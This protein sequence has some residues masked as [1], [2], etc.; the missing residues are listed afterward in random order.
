MKVGNTQLLM[1]LGAAVVAAGSAMAQS[2][3]F[4][5]PL[6][7]GSA[8]AGPSSSTTMSS[9]TMMMRQDDGDD[10]YEIRIEGDKVK[11]KV[12]GKEVPEDRVVREKDQIKILDENGK[13]LSTF[14]VSQ[15]GAVSAGK[16]SATT[17]A[18]RAQNRGRSGGGTRVA[19]AA[20][21]PPEPPAAAM[22]GWEP[23]K[24]MLGINM[25]EP[26]DGLLKAYGLEKGQSILIDRVIEGLPAEKAGIR[27]NDVITEIDGKK[28]ATPEALRD[29][30][31]DKEPGDTVTFTVMRKGGDQNIRVKLQAYDAE[32]LGGAMTTWVQP[33]DGEW[34]DEVKRKMD[35]AFKHMPQGR[36]LTFNDG[37]NGPIVVGPEG[38]FHTI[39]NEKLDAKIAE[40][41]KKL[42]ELDKKMAKLDELFAKLQTQLE[43]LPREDKP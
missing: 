29:V 15:Q 25:S 35:E 16:G 43:K 7:S 42:A 27:E 2:S 12:N 23:P 33:K 8:G 20:P 30:L 41:D 17:P 13:V 26:G 24:V 31:K 36:A 34:N 19:P 3:G 38:L 18:P 21:L 39:P 28:P 37:N 40:L 5:K 22:A 14:R 4:D 11:A 32:K 1:T 9:T 10:S 6:K